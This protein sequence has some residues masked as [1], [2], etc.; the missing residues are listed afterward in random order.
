MKKCKQCGSK[1]FYGEE[2]VKID[3]K[4]ENGKLIKTNE[5]SQGLSGDFWCDSC[6][7]NYHNEDFEVILA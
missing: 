3:F 2:N 6:G 5:E 4:L 7:K 1:S